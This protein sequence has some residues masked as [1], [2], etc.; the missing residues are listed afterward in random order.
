MGPGRTLHCLLTLCLCIG[1]TDLAADEEI[2][3]APGSQPNDSFL[4]AL[5]NGTVRALFRYSGQYRSSNLHL[6]QDSSTPDISDEK[7]QQYSAAGGF[8]GY[9]TGSWHNTSFGATIYAA[10]P[11]G[12][13]PADHKGLGGLYE[14]N[15][16]QDPY[17][18]LAR[19]RHLRKQRTRQ[20]SIQLWLYRQ[21]EGAQRLEI[22]RHGQGGQTAGIFK[23]ETDYTG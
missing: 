7:L 5:R 11:F 14:G 4:D 17:I 12:S 22:H 9:E 23:R 21:N 3:S 10:V 2:D 16:G 20:N 19:R 15:G 8:V 1:A 6:L 13:N 18:A